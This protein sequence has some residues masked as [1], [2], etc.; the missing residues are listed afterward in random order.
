MI[1]R[2]KRN[3]LAVSSSVTRRWQKP[4]CY[5][6]S[7]PATQLDVPEICRQIYENLAPWAFLA[8]N[9]GRSP[10]PFDKIERS[11]TTRQIVGVSGSLRAFGTRGIQKT[12]D[13]RSCHGGQ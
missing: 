4:T 7:P 9:S 10:A 6:R 5:Q 1:D 8:W 13:R 12:H 2:G 3:S 11:E